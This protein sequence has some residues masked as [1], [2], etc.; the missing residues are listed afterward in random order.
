MESGESKA[1]RRILDTL[2]QIL[3]TELGLSVMPNN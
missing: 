1:F 2:Y 3:N